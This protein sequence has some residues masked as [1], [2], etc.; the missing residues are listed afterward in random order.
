[1]LVLHRR[2]C[3]T[4]SAA[5]PPGPEPGSGTSGGKGRLR[6][7]Y[8]MLMKVGAFSLTLW[9]SS[10][11]I[12]VLWIFT[13]QT[14]RI[15]LSNTFLDEIH[16]R[17]GNKCK[18]QRECSALPQSTFAN[19]K[20]FVCRASP[21]WPTLRTSWSVWPRRCCLTWTTHHLRNTLVRT[22]AHLSHTGS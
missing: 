20:D 6:T 19:Q 12:E 1:M 14:G 18:N 16:Q 2:I 8:C 15:S 17:A 22:A 10:W 7:I 13:L 5:P 21:R 9:A 11:F 3:S 4:F